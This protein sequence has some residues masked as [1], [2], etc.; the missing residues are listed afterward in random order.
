GMRLDHRIGPQF[1]RAGLGWGGSCFPK[2]VK[3][4]VHMA[5]IH[6]AHPGLLRSVVAINSDQR[7]RRLPKLRQ[8]VGSL[9]GARVALFGAAFKANTDDIRHSPALELARLL[10]LEGADVHVYDPV[11]PE[12]RI[13]AA[14]PGVTV[15]KSALDAARG[16]RAV[17]VAT[18]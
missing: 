5:A 9:E 3:A 6:G 1:L 17:V 13:L 16:A 2:D 4:L 14:A 7:L 12:S 18:D 8:S 15:S 11:V 10:V